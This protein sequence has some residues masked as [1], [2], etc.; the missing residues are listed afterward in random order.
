MSF[1]EER[2]VPVQRHGEG[3]EEDEEAGEEGGLAD[4]DLRSLHQNGAGRDEDGGEERLPQ[5]VPTLTHD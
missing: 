2:V 5:P 3:A 1:G 4:G